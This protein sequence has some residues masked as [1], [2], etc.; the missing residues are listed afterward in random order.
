MRARGVR[1]FSITDHD[2]LGAYSDEATAALGELRLIAG[3]E[4]NSTYKENDVHVL[5]YGVSLDAQ[6]LTDLI[7]R[8]KHARVMRIEQMVEQLRG[9]G[10]DI[11]LDR[12]LAEA[13]EGASLGRPHVAKALVRAGAVADVNAAFKRVLARGGAGYVPSL[14]VTPHEAID[15]VAAAGGV[16]VLAHPGRL[17]DE[18]I[19]DELAEAGLVGLEVYHPSHS[20]SQ[21]ARFREKAEA[22]G[23]V[24]TGGSDF[25]DSRYSPD[26]VGMD[27]SEAELEPFL[28]LVG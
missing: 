17:K 14:H 19:V 5:G 18:S 20:G 21:R 3:L 1:W 16:P 7:D 13:G 23:L 9:A 26:G 15:V 28:D 12:V 8:N 4:I 27:V 22:L 24:V 2:S 25:H 10:F 6:V 11:S